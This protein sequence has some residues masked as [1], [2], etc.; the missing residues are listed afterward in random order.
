MRAC[1]CVRACASACAPLRAQL[2]VVVS[3]RERVCV[4]D[5]E[6]AIRIQ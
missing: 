1:L 5:Y 3:L 6:L 2:C 4:C